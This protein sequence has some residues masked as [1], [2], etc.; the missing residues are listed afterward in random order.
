[1]V[2]VVLVRRQLPWAD[3]GVERVG[4]EVRMSQIGGEVV[5]GGE[6]WRVG[7]RIALWRLGGHHHSADPC[8]IFQDLRKTQRC[9]I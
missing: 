3:R 6:G 1:M 2:L 5:C 8:G 7:G 4:D 9:K